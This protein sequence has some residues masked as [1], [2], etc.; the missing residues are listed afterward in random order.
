MRAESKPPRVVLDTGVL[1]SG[2]LFA[3]GNADQILQKV[4]REELTLI[5]SSFILQE[6]RK[7]LKQ[8]AKYKNEEIDEVVKS[9]GKISKTVDPHHRVKAFTEG[10]KET[11]R[12][13][14]CAVAGNASLIVSSDHHLRDLKSY[15]G[16]GIVTPLDFR[17]ILGE[18]D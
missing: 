1:L 8:K 17:R 6:F 10:K 11:N 18:S 14:E 13:L 4:R 7:I 5:T 3:G 16:I 2:L 12:I 9:L 15:Q